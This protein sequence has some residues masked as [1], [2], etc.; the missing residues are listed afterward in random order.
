KSEREKTWLQAIYGMFPKLLKTLF[1]I[2]YHENVR[3]RESNETLCI[4]PE[5]CARH[6]SS[7]LFSAIVFK[8]YRKRFPRALCLT[9]CIGNNRKCPAV[10][11]Q[12]PRGK[13]E[14]KLDAVV[15]RATFDTHA[16][17]SDADEVL[18]VPWRPPLQVYC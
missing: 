18:Q 17:V 8:K 2:N 3:K 5:F 7:R 16:N 12:F 13:K 9:R 10:L 15:P 11:L 4:G 1:G 6:I 14:S